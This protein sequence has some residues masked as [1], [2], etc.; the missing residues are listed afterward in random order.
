M[1]SRQQG[2]QGFVRTLV[3]QGTRVLIESRCNYCGFQIVGNS[4]ELEDEESRHR[5]HCLKAKMKAARKQAPVVPSARSTSPGT[6]TKRR[7]P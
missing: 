4:D 3:R 1:T 7:K 6:G 2:P 5:Q